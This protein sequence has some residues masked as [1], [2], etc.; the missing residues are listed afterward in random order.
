MRNAGEGTPSGGAGRRRA[1]VPAATSR[2]GGG[3]G[4][5]GGN[6]GVRHAAPV[7][8]VAGPR[9]GE[10][11]YDLG[12]DS[13]GTGYSWSA[14]DQGA[15]GYR[16]ASYEDRENAWADSDLP[17]GG[18]SW[19]TDDPS[20][21]LNWP[22]AGFSSTLSTR[23]ATRGFPP[24]PDEPLPMY[25]P[26]PFAAWNRGN[27]DSGSKENAF[28]DSA[29]AGGSSRLLTAATIT[30]DE[31]DTDYSIPAIKDPV[32]AYP[33]KGG[34]AASR[35]SGAPNPSAPARDGS[36]PA[37]ASG[38]RSERHGH[39][40]SGRGAAADRAGQSGHSERVGRAGRVKS[41]H[42]SVWL[43]IGTAA[44]IVA[45]VIV[46][47]VTTSLGGS[48]T[49][50]NKPTSPTR[51]A[52]PTL[53]VPPGK[54]AFIGSRATDPTPLSLKELF[55]ASFYVKRIYYHLTIQRSGQDCRTALI[56]TALQA[57][58]R[59][60]DCTQVLRA[61]YASRLQNAMATVGV[62]NLTDATS[63]S[64]AAIHAGRVQFVAQLA[65]K[66]GV[67]SRIGQ[68]PGLEEAVVKGHYLVLVWA[69]FINLAT[70]KTNWQQS[71]LTGFMNTLI[72]STIN[73]SLS[74]RMVDGRPPTPSPS[75]AG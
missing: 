23:N 28:R 64:A 41:R 8:S 70:P 3:G 25:P 54:W 14:D 19:M 7:P 20:D 48:T 31:F 18:Y 27:G 15:L 22:V 21:G 51:T 43:A 9:A 49:A 37:P 59:R 1:A 66:N 26:G 55:P 33:G 6:G 35:S 58:V 40:R 44:V 68:G 46:V 62:F 53:T 73:N 50:A 72:D 39:G 52:K 24:L 57:A 34:G 17:G 12:T 32:P 29:G 74:Y 10:A 56:G 65:A 75:P 45:A 61:S 4:G 5:S 42:H 11:G 63:A 67:T 16:Q 71:H 13:P 36:S 30:P 38:S 60:G 2:P 47:L 69:E